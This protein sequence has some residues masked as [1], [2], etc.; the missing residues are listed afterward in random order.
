[1]YDCMKFF[2]SLL[3]L[4]LC[5]LSVAQSV[6]A[7]TTVAT[8]KHIAGAKMITTADGLKYTDI[9]VGKGAPAKA[10]DQVTVNYVG[11]LTNGKRFDASADHGGTFAFPLGQGQVIHGWDEGVAGMRPG[12]DRKLIIP[13][14]LGYGAAGAGDLIP[15]NATLIFDVKLIS[16]G[17]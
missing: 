14:E 5:T 3:A 9:T 1:M 2:S 17:K 15:P 7:K 11:T 12:G 8:G 16:V 13:P 10:G 4:A 6:E